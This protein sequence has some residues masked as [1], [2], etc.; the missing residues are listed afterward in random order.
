MW[1]QHFPGIQV[2]LQNMEWKVFLHERQEKKNLEIF[3]SGWVGDYNDPNAFLDN[4]VTK[5]GYNDLGYSSPEFDELIKKGTMTSNL[6]ERAEILGKAEKHLLEDHILI[7]LYHTSSTRLVKPYV[8]GY[9]L[10][11][12]NVLDIFYSKDLRINR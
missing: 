4:L 3:R 2:A 1:K 12:T 9:N 8:E 7:P 6:K 10:T 11:S 5:A